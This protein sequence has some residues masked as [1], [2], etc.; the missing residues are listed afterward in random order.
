LI[1]NH[2]LE[3]CLQAPA[4][5]NIDY[6]LG[7]LT[8]R[9]ERRLESFF[10]SPRVSGKNLIQSADQNVAQRCQEQ[11]VTIAQS[12][13]RVGIYP[14]LPGWTSRPRV[15]GKSEPKILNDKERRTTCPIKK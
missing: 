3:T 11:P 5:A 13:P 10:G 12:G 8:S 6:F 7:F 15:S 9:L 4:Q 2:F 1:P 14:A